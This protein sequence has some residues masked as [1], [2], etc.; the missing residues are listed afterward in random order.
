MFDL[1]PFHSLDEE[2]WKVKWVYVVL[3]QQKPKHKAVLIDKQP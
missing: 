3:S 2:K 1:K